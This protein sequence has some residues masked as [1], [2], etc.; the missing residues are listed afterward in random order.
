MTINPMK[1][2]VL[3]L[4]LWTSFTCPPP[5]APCPIVG[6]EELKIGF[7][8]VAKVFDGYERTKVSDAAL[9]KKGQQKESELEGRLNELKK[10]RESLELMNDESRD[11]KVRDIEAKA[12]E[13]KR[14]RANAARDLRRERDEIAQEILKEI[15]QTVEAYAK[16]NGFSLMLDE[17]SILFGQAGFEATDA[18][19]K[20]LNSRYGARR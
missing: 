17:R 12:D 13:L 18:V 20:D 1:T 3:T 19:L 10:L 9:E 15:R 6:A 14:F 8:N 5:L 16:A 11:T 7:V 4:I 2:T